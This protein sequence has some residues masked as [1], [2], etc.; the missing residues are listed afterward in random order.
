MANAE[1][2]ASVGIDIGTSTT[3]VVFSELTVENT[4]GPASVPRIDITNKFVTYRSPIHGT[5]LLAP[6]LIDAETLK[7]I[8]VNEYKQAGMTPGDVRTGAAIITGETARAEN[9]EQVLAALSELAG[10]FVVATAGPELESVLAARGTGIDRYSTETSRVVANLDIGGGTT[11]IAAYQHG[12]LLG[13]SCLDIG[14]RLVRIVDGRISYMFRSV[15][16]IAAAAGLEIKVGDP[17]DA[18]KLL[19]LARL[20]S[21]QLA[22]ALRLVPR[23]ELHAQLYTNDGRPL[24][25]D[26]SPTEISFSGGVADLIDST[27]QLDPF[28]YGDLGVLL[29]RAITE[30]SAFEL[31]KRHRGDETIAATVVGAGVHTTE[32]SGSTIEFAAELLPLRNVPIIR[33]ASAQS[34]TPELLADEIAH[35]IGLMN[36]DDESAT[37]AISFNGEELDG[38]TKVQEYAKAIIRG[39]RTVLEGSEPLVIVMELDRGKVL[40]QTMAALRGR[41]DDVVCIDGVQTTSG[42]FIDIGEPLGAGRAVPVVLKT[43]V[44]N[45]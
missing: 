40:G 37:V 11:N 4:A 20:M 28:A 8:V 27:A 36:P 30:D 34:A 16:K 17:A 32:I 39:A 2:I 14:G 26:I 42:D 24:A 43:L 10:D 12:R 41:R 15:A 18:D 38:F 6:D 21:R 25:D 19:V 7:Q 33:I 5:P 1:V 29:G 13:T 45:D 35:R 23:D 9:A 3:Q 44:F 22:M 31:I